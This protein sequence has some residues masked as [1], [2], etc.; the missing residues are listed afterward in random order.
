MPARL[1]EKA[2]FEPIPGPKEAYS[3]R[4]RRAP[5]FGW[6]QFW[7]SGVNSALLADAF[8]PVP[9]APWLGHPDF[10]FGAKL[11]FTMLSW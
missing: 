4:M 10:G 5:A 8:L 3:V 6:W 11:P 2:T 7:A 1:G 9:M